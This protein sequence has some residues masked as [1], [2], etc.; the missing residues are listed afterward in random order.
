MWDKIV[1]PGSSNTRSTNIRDRVSTSSGANGATQPAQPSTA[2]ASS[3][4]PPPADGPDDDAAEGRPS[5]SKP[6][7]DLTRS[8]E[9]PPAKRQKND[10]GMNKAR[11]FP[12]LQDGGDKLCY[13]TSRANECTIPDCYNSH[14][15]KTYL[16]QN[17]GRHIYLDRPDGDGKQAQQCPVRMRSVCGCEVLCQ[18]L[19]R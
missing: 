14:D 5:S 12:R 17:K 10:K 15:L 1:A 11:S 2:A 7:S 9:E 16:E 4:L 6:G 18:K 13:G 19:S 3:D 8:T